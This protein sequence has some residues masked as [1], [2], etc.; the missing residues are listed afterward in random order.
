MAKQ[1]N[2]VTLETFSSW[3]DIND[4][5]IP[6]KFNSTKLSVKRNT[7]Y[8]KKRWIKDLKRTRPGDASATFVKPFR[9]HCDYKSMSDD[10]LETVINRIDYVISIVDGST[11]DWIRIK[12]FFQRSLPKHLRKYISSVD[13]HSRKQKPNDFDYAVMNYWKEKT[14]VTLFIPESKLHP[15]NYILPPANHKQYIKTY[16]K[17]QEKHT[18][19]YGK[20]KK[21]FLQ[22]FFKRNKSKEQLAKHLK[23]FPYQSLLPKYFPKDFRKHRGK[24]SSFVD[25]KKIQS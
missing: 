17:L 24:Q 18:E 4:I 12:C 7:K 20:R 19:V 5:D 9:K 22:K 23:D 21:F 1:T 3:Q 15:I 14:G 16:E 25:S 10:D 11:D 13:V 2:K 8:N 6:V